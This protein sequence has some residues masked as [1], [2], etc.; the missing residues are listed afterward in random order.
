M[1]LRALQRGKG[2]HG[3]YPD[4]LRLHSDDNAESQQ[5]ASIRRSSSLQDIGKLAELDSEVSIKQLKPILRHKG[6]N[7][8]SNNKSEGQHQKQPHDE[9]GVKFGH[10]EVK[11]VPKDDPLPPIQGKGVSV[12]N[13]AAPTSKS[14][15]DS[16]PEVGADA[17]NQAEKNLSQD[18][19]EGQGLSPV[20]EN[21]RRGGLDRS[22]EIFPRGLPVEVRKPVTPTYEDYPEAYWELRSPTVQDPA[23]LK[24]DMIDR[25]RYRLQQISSLK[26]KAVPRELAVNKL[27]SYRKWQQQM[28]E[29]TPTP[30][31]VTA[32]PSAI[33]A[34]I[35]NAAPN[36]GSHNHAPASNGTV[37]KNVKE[38]PQTLPVPVHTL[39]VAA[40]SIS[41]SA[42]PGPKKRNSFG[43]N[44]VNGVQNGEHVTEDELRQREKL[45]TAAMAAG[46]QGLKGGALKPVKASVVNLGMENADLRSTTSTS[47]IY[48]GVRRVVMTTRPHS[49]LAHSFKQGQSSVV[50]K[51]P[52]SALSSVTGSNC[53]TVGSTYRVPSA[54]SASPPTTSVTGAP[55]SNGNDRTGKKIMKKFKRLQVFSEKGGD[56]RDVAGEDDVLVTPP[57]KT[58]YLPQNRPPTYR[59]DMRNYPPRVNGS[60]ATQEWGVVG[61]ERELGGYPVLASDPRGVPTINSPV[62]SEAAASLNF[63]FRNGEVIVSRQGKRPLAV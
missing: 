24:E 35:G 22:P 3:S 38:K 36:G 44:H 40:T 10:K 57:D 61:G 63:R 59:L 19:F 12:A 43:A 47:D 9:K 8:R 4:L 11:L 53:A 26:L 51:H 56:A 39:S 34:T 32:T 37:D 27:N 29:A 54:P 21:S 20:H 15:V 45:K 62:K 1:Q 50:R 23:D 55:A 13:H 5:L 33:T 52:G 14:R 28:L 46:E 30:R 7:R 31:G 2:H 16:T 48:T 25:D 17:R 60:A 41:P 49:D 58:P 18:A 42:H 6:A